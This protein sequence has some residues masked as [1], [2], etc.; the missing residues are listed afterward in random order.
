VDI[1]RLV[2]LR[3]K[4]LSNDVV[5]IFIQR[6]NKK[7]RN[8][9]KAFPSWLVGAHLNFKALRSQRCSGALAS[10][11]FVATA[12]RLASGPTSLPVWGSGR[13]HLAAVGTLVDEKGLNLGC[14][15]KARISDGSL[16][17]I[18]IGAAVG[19]EKTYNPSEI[20]IRAP[21]D[22]VET[23]GFTNRPEDASDGDPITIG[24]AVV[25]EETEITIGAPV[26][27]VETE[28]FT[29]R[30]V[31]SLDC[32]PTTELYNPSGTT[33]GASANVVETKGPGDSLDGGPTTG[34]PN[35]AI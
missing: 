34:P 14:Y 20:T 10:S 2:G 5:V 19:V 8:N 31:D 25:V 15:F 16:V 29:N 26:D 1:T 33:I 24:A 3:S 12:N 32:G 22:V 11:A 13:S 7:S 4:K 28:G 21:V 23:E 17:R 18:T 30:P 35:C 6:F 27:V 9:V